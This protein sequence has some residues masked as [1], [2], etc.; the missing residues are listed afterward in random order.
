MTLEHGYP[1]PVTSSGKSAPG[2]DPRIR[3]RIQIGMFRLIRVDHT[4]C[5]QVAIKTHSLSPLPRIRVIQDRGV[6][7]E[8][9]CIDRRVMREIRCIVLDKYGNHFNM[10][11]EEAKPIT[12]SSLF[13]FLLSLI[14]RLV[15]HW[16][17]RPDEKQTQK[18]YTTSCPPSLLVVHSGSEVERVTISCRWDSSWLWGL[19]LNMRTNPVCDR[20]VSV[21]SVQPASTQPQRI[22]AYGYGLVWQPHIHI[23]WMMTNMDMGLCS[24]L[25]R[26]PFSYVTRR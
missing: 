25:K 4:N 2:P 7:C 26:M 17:K 9:L 11:N 13:I 15:L 21:S 19:P 6:L 8:I 24:R 16:S 20:C 3:H 10:K 5:L 12:F 22:W 18:E 1:H 14:F 23:G